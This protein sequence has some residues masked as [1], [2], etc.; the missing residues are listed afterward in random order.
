MSQ[1]TERVPYFSTDPEQCA[2]PGSLT[3]LILMEVI[4]SS[5]HN[6]PSRTQQT[7]NFFL[8][9]HSHFFYISPALAHEPL[10]CH[11][12]ASG[13]HSFSLSLSFLPF[14]ALPPSSCYLC[15]GTESS[16]GKENGG[17]RRFCTL[18]IQPVHVQG[19]VIK[20][21]KGQ[22]SFLI[23]N[24]RMC[25]CVFAYTTVH[26]YSSKHQRC[27]WSIALTFFSSFFIP[28]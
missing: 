24:M 25:M 14:A 26:I 22:S 10:P 28:L 2:P 4:Y 17:D 21:E 8:L 27:F 11:L 20:S 15:C 18:Q 9:S 5:T 1:C 7:F 12:T 3:A 6:P 16:R 23:V 13:V 19:V